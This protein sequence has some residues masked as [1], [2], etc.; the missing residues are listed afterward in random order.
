MTDTRTKSEKRAELMGW[1]AGQDLKDLGIPS[2]C[3]FRREDLARAWARGY[4][5]GNLPAKA[6]RAR[7][8]RRKIFS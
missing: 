4:A 8:A 3:P 5:A 2:R 1:R 7:A 6:S